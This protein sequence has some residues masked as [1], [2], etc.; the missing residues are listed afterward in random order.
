[1]DCGSRESEAHLRCPALPG[2]TEN[3][4][5]LLMYSSLREEQAPISSGNALILLLDR[6]S[7]LS[8]KEEDKGGE[9]RERED[10]TFQVP[11][12]CWQDGELVF[13]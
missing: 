13:V 7:L 6:E 10:R 9:E 11:N 4:A 5:L 8:A 12:L 1:M 3:F 2:M